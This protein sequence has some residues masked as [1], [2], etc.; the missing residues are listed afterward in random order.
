MVTNQIESTLVDQTYTR[1]TCDLACI[2]D[3]YCVEFAIGRKYDT[4]QGKCML[5][6]ATCTKSADVTYDLYTSSVKTNPSKT[7]SVCTHK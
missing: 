3:E 7:A 1:D 6:K 2:K 4:N 5:F